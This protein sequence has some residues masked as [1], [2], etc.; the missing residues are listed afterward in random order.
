MSASVNDLTSDD[1]HGSHG[2]REASRQ[3]HAV[4]ER[5]LECGQRRAATTP[6]VSPTAG[7]SFVDC[8][9]CNPPP[10]GTCGVPN[11]TAVD[12]SFDGVDPILTKQRAADRT[13]LPTISRRIT[14]R[15]STCHFP[16]SVS[17]GRFL[18][19]QRRRKPIFSFATTAATR[20]WAV[21]SRRAAGCVSLQPDDRKSIV[22]SPKYRTV[23][24]TRWEVA[25]VS[26]RC[27]KKQFGLHAG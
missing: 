19:W 10:V 22:K 3:R 7:S 18:R 25:D 2:S 21:V 17:R 11:R 8:T 12:D 13:R 6:A 15:P 26:S 9:R 23:T 4:S 27:Q 14:A 16:P 1:P 24:K 5:G 20:I